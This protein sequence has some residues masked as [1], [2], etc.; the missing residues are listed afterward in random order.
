VGVDAEHRR[1]VS[2]PFCEILAG[3][4]PVSF[5]AEN[6]HAIAFAGY[7]QTVFGHVLIVPRRHIETVDAMDDDS[8]AAMMQLAVRVARAIRAELDPSGISLWQS[9]GPAAFQ[10][11]PHVH[12]H[13]QARQHNDGLLRVYPA[14]PDPGTREELDE[15]ARRLRPHFS[16]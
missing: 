14:E 3:R 10:E 16:A 13:V 12:L 2:C 11:V 6:D 7:R 1:V 15:L 5:V 4:A 9:N 8:A